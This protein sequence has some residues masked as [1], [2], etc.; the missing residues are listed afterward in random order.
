ND[1]GLANNVSPEQI[2]D[3]SHLVPEEDLVR[4]KSEVYGLPIADLFGLSVDKELL[5][6][7]PKEL[8]ETYQMVVF[9]QEDNSL[10]VGLLNP[11][12]FKSRE[13]MDFVA[14]AKNLSVKYFIAAPTALKNILAQ[15]SGLAA[16]VE[17]ALGGISDRFAPL[18]QEGKSWAEVGLEDVNQAAP[19]TKLVSS[20]LKY[21]V[22]NKA[23]DVHIEPFGDKTRV[24]Y[25]IDGILRSVAMLPGH[26]HSAIISRIK[27]MS[28]LKLDETRIPQDGRIRIVITGRKI[29][30]RVATLPLLEK[31]KVVMRILDPAQKIFTL[32]DLGFWG[33]ALE[34]MKRNLLRPHGMFL[35][36][37]PTGSGKTTTIYA[38]L[39]IL[40]KEKVNIIT[41]EDPI[42]YYMEGINQSQVK[43]DIGYSFASGIR[44]VVRQDPNVIMVGEIRDNETA[45]LGT[46]ASLTGHIVLSTLHTN[47]AFG[48]IPRLIDMK[49][50]PFLIAS[51]VNLVLA[52]RL[53]RKICE[54]CR[55]PVEISPEMEKEII[56]SLTGIKDVNLE[57]FRDT[58][59]GRLKF[60]HGRGCA[61][62]G[63]EGYKGRT[64]IFE[65]LEITEEMKKII[66]EGCKIDDAKAEFKRQ[67]MLEMRRDGYIKALRGVTT[68]EEVM[69]VA[70]E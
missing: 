3:R 28:N 36:T 49:I 37:G 47:D 65:V 21:A 46:H 63:Q 62:C 6:I 19:V 11:G 48:A 68:I 61:R 16:E 10:K 67:G 58:K 22:D 34:I 18:I 27:V 44:S 38:I 53:V 32:E 70:M 45:E 59:T 24:R 39:K 41:L 35:V 66:V 14:K 40:N 60:Y 57:E 29:D 69:R 50:E 30:L 55:E 1:E 4:A 23:S 42:E 25:R 52:Q 17:E 7:L 2:L 54:F 8:A 15:Y 12:D 31:E 5:K 56:K 51:S 20:I 9:G 64:V 13:A 26:I 33:Y 43:P